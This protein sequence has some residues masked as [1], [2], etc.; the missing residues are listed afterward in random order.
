[1]PL[2]ITIKNLVQN[3]LFHK[4][5]S[6]QSLQISST[7]N[8]NFILKLLPCAKKLLIQYLMRFF[9]SASNKIRPTL[10]NFIGQ[11]EQ[12]NSKLNTI[13]LTLLLQFVPRRL[14]YDQ[15]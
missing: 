11:R 9:Q 15:F 8:F 2:I 10:R 5:S 6:L 14:F 7:F 13:V 3:H 4:T 12:T 1:M